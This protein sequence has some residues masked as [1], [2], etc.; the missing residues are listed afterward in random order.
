LDTIVTQ[1][2]LEDI[3][4]NNKNQDNIVVLSEIINSIN[5]NEIY[6]YNPLLIKGKDGVGK[7]YLLKK[8]KNILNEKAVYYHATELILSF[9]KNIK[10]DEFL[11]EIDKYECIII[12][13]IH[14]LGNEQKLQEELAYVI[15]VCLNNNKGIII[16]I[17]LE[18]KNQELITQLRSRISMGLIINIHEPD[19]DIRMRYAELCMDEYSIKLT[20]EHTLIIA[21]KCTQYRPIR[22]SIINIKAYQQR[23]GNLPDINELEKILLQSGDNINLDNELI[24]NTVAA[25]YGYNIKEIC[26]KKRDSQLVEARQ[27]AM[28]LCRKLLGEAYAEIGYI[29]GGKDHSTVIYAVRK[30]EKLIVRNKDMHIVVTELTNVCK[31]QLI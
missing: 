15:E 28:Y 19:L 13:D 26:G 11:L 27:I 6:P 20:K 29:F 16:S 9:R 2:N 7:T 12:D 8:I 10:I 25:R 21:R 17:N 22:S 31:N 14:L 30:I 4:V 24:I 23:I 3:L 5:N 1:Y 18:N